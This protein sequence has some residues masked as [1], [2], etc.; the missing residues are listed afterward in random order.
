MKIY[1]SHSSGYDYKTEFYDPLKSSVL[2]REHQILFPHDTENAGM[3]SKNLI[4]QSDL[5]IA[6]VSYASTGQGIELGWA[7]DSDISI[8]CIHKK[9]TKV[10]STLRHI[11]NEFIEY[12]D[13]GDMIVKL[14]DRLQ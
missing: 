14:T 10:S 12:E 1:L 13:P 6:E 3:H 5:V 2:A 8:L 4:T 9:E 7:D 11:T